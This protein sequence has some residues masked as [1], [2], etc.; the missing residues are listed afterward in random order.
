METLQVER[1]KALQAFQSVNYD[2]KKL[3]TELFGEQNFPGKIT[4]RIKTFKD[5]CQELGIDPTDVIPTGGMLDKDAKSMIAGCKLNVI[6]RA[7]NEGWEPDWNNSRQPKWRCW[8]YFDSPGFRF[9]GAGCNFSNSSVGSRLCFK[10]EE[11]AIYA[12]AQ[13]LD[14]FKEHFEI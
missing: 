6:V 13:F 12:G 14:L 5:A 9:H 8:F 7:L 10:N 3:L 1:T 2:G 11:L 4:D